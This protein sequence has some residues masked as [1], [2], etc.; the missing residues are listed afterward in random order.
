MMIILIWFCQIRVKKMWPRWR[1]LWQR[2]IKWHFQIADWIL[3]HLVSGRAI[4]FF[5]RSRKVCFRSRSLILKLKYKFLGLILRIIAFK[6]MIQ[7]NNCRIIFRNNAWR[8]GFLQIIEW[9]LKKVKSLSMKIPSKS[10]V[11]IFL[12]CK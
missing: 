1:G 8:V 12:S 3:H 7:L 4:S 5:L 6:N 2:R 9:C 10:S 11:W